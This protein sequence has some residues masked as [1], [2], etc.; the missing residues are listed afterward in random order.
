[1]TGMTKVALGGVAMALALLSGCGGHR[2]VVRHE[3]GGVVHVTGSIVEGTAS[4]HAAMTE[5]CGGRWRVVDEEVADAAKAVGAAALD[6]SPH[7]AA[8]QQDPDR[9]IGYACA[10]R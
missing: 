10:S 2:H 4:A 6:L 7:A 1:M 9:R 3:R 5:H 8:D